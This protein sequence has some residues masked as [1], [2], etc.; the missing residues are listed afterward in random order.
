MY[1]LWQGS[2]ASERIWGTSQGVTASCI[3]EDVFDETVWLSVCPFVYDSKDSS[4]GVGCS[5]PLGAASTISMIM[6][7]MGLT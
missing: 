4:S 5:A 7:D 2:G 6:A 1:V 3:F